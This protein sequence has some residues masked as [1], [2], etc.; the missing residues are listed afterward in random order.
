MYQTFQLMPGVTLRCVEAKRFKQGCLSIQFLRP[1][2]HEEAA[3]NALI[4]SILLR[5][6]VH[7]PD[8]R[9]ITQHLD[10]L[11]GASVGEMVRRVGDYQTVGLY[12]GFIDDRFAL[13][14]DC[15]LEPILDFAREL[16]LEPLVINGGFCPEYVNGEKRNLIANIESQLN[17]K[18]AYAAAQLMKKMCSADS[19][20]IPRL[21]T[22]EA[23]AA[24]DPVVAYEHYKRLLAESPVE[25]FY[26]GSADPQ[27]IASKI[28]D[29]FASVYRCPILLPEHTSFC[30]GGG[31]DY[32]EKMEISQ[33]KLCMGFTTP[34]TVNSED[35]AAMQVLN[36]LF[37][38]G[39]TSKL[40][41]QVR[42]KLSLCYSIGSGYYGAKGILTVS[43]GIDSSKCDLVK[44]EIMRQLQI[45]CDGGIAD[46]ELT[47]AKESLLSSLRGVYDSPGA[48]ESYEFVMAVGKTLL[49][50]DQYRQCIQ[51]V[52]LDQVIRAA[53]T[54]ALHTTYFL[55]G[56]DA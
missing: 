41:N 1:M 17:D 42:E 46:T 26:V 27:I 37:G 24:V 11:Y 52:D 32:E 28:C 54:L 2:C 56:V 33:G 30:D 55:K 19:F 21:G 29:I 40:F 10:D 53:K 35:F 25:V 50:T 3:V 18:R 13:T 14:G 34:I 8:L 43:A 16:L 12:F 44:Q 7:R 49:T 6:T 48:I 38:A 9:A 47:A 23:V 20:G 15:I 4:P 31:G 51:S 5:G 39:M 22:K 45:C 36:A